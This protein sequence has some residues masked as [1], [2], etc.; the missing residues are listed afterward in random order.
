[1]INKV[2]P[3]KLVGTM[4]VI[5]KG[6]SKVVKDN[7]QHLLVQLIERANCPHQ[8]LTGCKRSRRLDISNIPSIDISREETHIPA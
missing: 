5:I 3:L 6:N 7:K 8:L 1:M 4:F 2:D